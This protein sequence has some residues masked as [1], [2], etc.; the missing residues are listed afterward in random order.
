MLA[1]PVCLGHG[2]KTAQLCPRSHEFCIDFPNFDIDLMRPSAYHARAFSLTRSGS[3]FRL[4]VSS[5]QHHSPAPV[6]A[7]PDAAHHDLLTTTS[8]L[9]ATARALK[10]GNLA[11]LSAKTFRSYLL[12]Q[13]KCWKPCFKS[14]RLSGSRNAC[15][16]IA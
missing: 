4:P 12:G 1:P 8:A 11:V 7:R 6:P 5:Q 2:L 9:H 14:E 10:L 16:I 3:H 13:Q 15:V